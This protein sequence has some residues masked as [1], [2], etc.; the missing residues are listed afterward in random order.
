MEHLRGKATIGVLVAALLAAG[1]SAA[2]SGK[3]VE[4]GFIHR[5]IVHYVAIRTYL[6]ENLCTDAS[7]PVHADVAAV[8][9][10]FRVRF[11]ELVR[12]AESSPLFADANRQNVRVVSDFAARPRNERDEACA[13][14]R[15][16]IAFDLN[17]EQVYF[18]QWTRELQRL[19]RR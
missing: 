8:V 3:E 12:L 14:L 17:G 6:P 16:E 19:E 4:D 2:T 15:D 13:Q 18:D 1:P 5:T 7:A 11:P 9:K 10:R